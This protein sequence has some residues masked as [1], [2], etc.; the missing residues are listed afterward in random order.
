MKQQHPVQQAAAEPH[1]QARSRQGYN[2]ERSF[3]VAAAGAGSGAGNWQ[4]T[5]AN[6]VTPA[7]IRR[8]AN[9]EEERRRA[10][11]ANTA[12]AA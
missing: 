11:R 10:K 7:T 4:T 1:P 6:N 2:S 12:Q 5:I 8:R 9:R 3:P